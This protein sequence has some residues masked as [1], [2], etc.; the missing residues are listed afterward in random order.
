M[1]Y[2]TTSELTTQNICLFPFNLS[3]LVF[4]TLANENVNSYQT[5]ILKTEELLKEN[6]E[7]K[8]ENYRLKLKVNKNKPKR[9]YS[10]RRTNLK[11]EYECPHTG[12]THKYSSRIA[13]NLHHKKKHSKIDAQ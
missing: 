6:E 4:P 8:K 7:L 13:L 11:K 12:C 3:Q 10:E 9:H 2:S 1:E 5:L